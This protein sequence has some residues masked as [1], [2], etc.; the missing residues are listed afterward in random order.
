MTMPPLVD[1]P[2]PLRFSYDAMR[3]VLTIEGTDFSGGFFRTL[4]ADG[5]NVGVPFVIVRRDGAIT[6]RVLAPDELA[7]PTST[8]SDSGNRAMIYTTLPVFDIPKLEYVGTFLGMKFYKDERLPPDV[9]I[10]RS[11]DQVVRFEGLAVA[12]AAGDA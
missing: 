4:G 6:I 7:P 3:D 8:Q 9:V 12:D 11:G 5:I 1:R 10:V 2:A